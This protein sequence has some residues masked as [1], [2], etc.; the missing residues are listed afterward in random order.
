MK[1]IA[2]ILLL[3]T[4]YAAPV[5]AGCWETWGWNENCGSGSSDSSQDSRSWNNPNL[6]ESKNDGMG[7]YGYDLDEDVYDNSR[8]SG[9]TDAYGDYTP[10]GGGAVER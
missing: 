8:K 5:F 2:F 9:C 3:I 7:Y 1:K 4:L 10:C 6:G